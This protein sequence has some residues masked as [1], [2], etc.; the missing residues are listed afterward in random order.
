MSVA[1]AANISAAAAQ[2]DSQQ[3]NS[4]QLNSSQL[5][6][7]QPLHVEFS[8]PSECGPRERLQELARELLGFDA[9]R[10]SVAVTAQVSALSER[11]Y[12][13]SLELRGAVSGE[14]TLFGVNCDEA[15]RAG[16]V[17]V[18][19][20]IN[21]HALVTA[22]SAGSSLAR[23]AEA[24]T[25]VTSGN[26]KQSRSVSPAAPAN[27]APTTRDARPAP[28]ERE[29]QPG[30]TDEASDTW[31]FAVTG[32]LAYGLTPAPRFGVKAIVGAAFYDVQ[33]RAFGFFDPS[34]EHTD[35][36]AGT[37]RFTSLGGGAEVC[38][39]L[40]SWSRLDASLCGGW[41][42]TEVSASAPNVEDSTVQDAW[43]SAGVLG[44][45]LGVR[46]VERVVLV[47]EA[48]Y[49]IPSSRPRFVVDVTGSGRSP[50]HRV[51]S[52]VLAGLGLQF[53]L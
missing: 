53:G 33:V 36:V 22:P 29:T 6:V 1:G 42:F 5:G 49:A 52:G 15:L 18:A 7:P 39:K 41:S 10:A 25:E 44:A 28:I 2:P 38:A 26:A 21:P 14:R 20:A 32:R 47:M 24:T 27:V 30:P 34:T 46:L 48:G 9:D 3:T 23:R 16:A 8:G 19:L 13:L 45:G 4:S 31:L 35:V 17:V 50:V 51:E 40:W 11:R 12:Q 43:V 37:V